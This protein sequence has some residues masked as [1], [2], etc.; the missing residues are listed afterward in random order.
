MTLIVT[1]R[2]E[3]DFAEALHSEWGFLT[4]LAKVDGEPLQLEPYQ[5]A[6]LRNRSKFRWVTKSRQ[7]GYSFLFA[8]EALARSHLRPNYTGV[9]VS[10]NLE[11]AKSKIVTA[12][13]LYEELPLAFQRD[14]SATARRNWHSPA[15]TANSAF[16]ASF[17]APARRPGAAPG[18][19]TSMKLLTTRSIGRCTRG[20][21][22]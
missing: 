4:A 16:L 3:Q 1:K 2:T 20:L 9:F 12:R 5:L 19:G 17:R 14:W 21:R 18:T 8:L 6:F 11:D 15:M 7:V 13:Q 22:R 10:Y